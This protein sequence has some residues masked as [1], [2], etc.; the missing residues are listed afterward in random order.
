MPVG[1]NVGAKRALDMLF[2]GQT[3]DAATALRDGLVSRVVPP[4]KLD[5][6]TMALANRIAEQ[7]PERVRI[8]CD[9]GW[10][11]AR[12]Q[13]CNITRARDAGEQQCEGRHAAA[14]HRHP[15]DD[16][17]HHGGTNQRR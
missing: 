14:V 4:E 1:R 10:A 12:R 17:Q 2:T 15:D 5:E 9:E 8:A 7:P 6:E 13:R 11:L 16:E 3:I